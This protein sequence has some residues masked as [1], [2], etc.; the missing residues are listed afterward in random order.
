METTITLEFISDIKEHLKAFEHQLK[1]IHGVRVELVAP[2]DHTAPALVGIGI[3]PSEEQAAQNVAQTVYNFL[4]E[5]QSVQGQKKIS[6]VTI[7]GDRVDI[8]DLPVEDIHK[9][10]VTA[11]EGQ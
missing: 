9:I 11:Q 2:R 10:I 7:E 5:E 4:R 8:E 3:D 6:L 1:H